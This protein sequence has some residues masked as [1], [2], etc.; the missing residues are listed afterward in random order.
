MLRLCTLVLLLAAAGCS[1]VFALDPPEHPT[2]P[3][4]FTVDFNE[5]TKLVTTWKT[6]GRWHYDSEQEAELVQRANGRGEKFCKSIHPF[7]DTP[8]WHLVTQGT[9]Y[10]V[11]PKL[12]ECCV[13]CTT[14]K[15]GCSMLKPDWLQ[16]AEF[17]GQ[18][19]TGGVDV[20]KWKKSG[21]TST[22]YYYNTADDKQ[23]PVEL[24][25]VPVSYQRFHLDTYKEGPV[26]EK[27]FTIPDTCTSQCPVTSACTLVRHG[28]PAAQ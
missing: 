23:T 5:T 10:I 21:T 22:S 24:D 14:D 26:D 12:N 11:F 17:Q 27:R 13:C 25:I 19:K 4:A 18:L 8:C 2:F 15:S 9:R 28:R 20:W 1:S 3:K 7:T 16:D 6:D